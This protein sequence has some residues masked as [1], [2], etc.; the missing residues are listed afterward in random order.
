MANIL[1]EK[2][3]MLNDLIQYRRYGGSE[4]VIPLDRYTVPL[5]CLGL[6]KILDFSF[7]RSPQ[8]AVREEKFCDPG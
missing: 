6:L 1:T 7:N 3:S 4:E 5:L 2:L 8:L